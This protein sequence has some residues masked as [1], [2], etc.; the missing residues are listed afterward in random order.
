MKMMVR[1]NDDDD[2][3]DGD[4]DDDDDYDDDHDDD[5]DDDDANGQSIGCGPSRYLTPPLWLDM[6]RRRAGRFHPEVLL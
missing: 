3:D 5:D 2:D 6:L 4:D 1:K